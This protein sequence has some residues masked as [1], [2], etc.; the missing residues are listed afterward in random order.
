MKPLRLLSLLPNHSEEFYDRVRAI[1]SSRWEASFGAPVEYETIGLAEALQVLSRALHSDFAALLAEPALSEIELQVR[2]RQSSLAGAGPFAKFHDGDSTLAHFCYAVARAVRPEAA[3][4]T[5][6]CYG[7]TSAFLLQAMNVNQRGH[8]QSIDLPPLGKDADAFVGWLVP[9]KLR[10]RWTIHRGT[11]ARLLPPLLS[12]KGAIDLFVHDSLHTYANMAN[13]LRI[14]WPAIRAG[15]VLIADD[16]EGNS[17]FLELS[18]RPDVAS[19]VVIEE[20]GKTALLGI[21]VK[22]G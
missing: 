5:G 11:S 14:A 6:V 13:E 22:V 4:E 8:L 17:A 7:V 9:S 21:A 18:K 19:A 3:F 15:G 1:A 10:E 20:L 16:V 12:E 2:E